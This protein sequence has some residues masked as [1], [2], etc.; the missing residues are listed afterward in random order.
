MLQQNTLIIFSLV[1]LLNPFVNALYGLVV[2]VGAE[3]REELI[4]VSDA[5][6]LR[7][8]NKVLDGSYILVAD[9]DLSELADWEPIGK[10]NY[11]FS[12]E[13]FANGLQITCMNNNYE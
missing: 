4:V 7:G 12:G 3:G 6:G 9:V 13:F 5:E 11:S 2:K 1:L 8:I 10:A